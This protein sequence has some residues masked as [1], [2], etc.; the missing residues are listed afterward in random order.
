MSVTHPESA[1]HPMPKPEPRLRVLA[2][3]DGTWTVEVEPQSRFGARV[4]LESEGRYGCTC[5]SSA[6][7]VRDCPHIV[8]VRE[9]ERDRVGWGPDQAPMADRSGRGI[10]YSEPRFSEMDERV[11]PA[12]LYGTP[13]RRLEHGR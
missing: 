10:G 1:I 4:V 9:F 3:R 7:T 2:M 12:D 11:D 6:R 5:S 8:A 13:W